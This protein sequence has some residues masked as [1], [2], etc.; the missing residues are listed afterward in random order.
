M[1][2]IL[3]AYFLMA[4]TFTLAKV[5]VSYM[6]PVYF[7]AFRMIL[8]GIMI[9][10]FL[11]AF[12]REKWRFQATDRWLL[13]QIVIFHI[14]C[15]YIFEFWAM[16][17][18]TSAKACLLYNLSPFITA[19]LCYLLYKQKLSLQKWSALILGFLGMFPIL[20]AHSSSEGGLL[21]IGFLSMAEIA[22]L[23]AVAAS[24]Y[25]WIVMKEL[26]VI[27]GY[28]PVMVNGIGML[29]GG[30]AALSTA[31]AFEGFSPFIWVQEPGDMVG[32]M[33]LP[34]L[35]VFPNTVVMALGSMICLIIIANI[36]GYNLYGYLLKRYS[37]TFLSFCGFITP[38][39]ASIFGWFFLS[40]CVTMP[41]FISLGIT[42]ISLYLFYK[43]EI[44]SV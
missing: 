25:G 3:L 10:G 36:I 23:A 34:H 7:I 37:P 17:Y 33:L 11:Y 15:A 1:W 40:E 16:Q 32:R 13:A 44:I 8:A 41:F 2:L 20:A 38:F 43:D 21:S 4:S 22:L 24:A 35:G 26:I 28:S 12:K 31:V 6:L 9:L 27:K 14:Y 39:F 5:A 19:L 30:L 29:G 42:I 18:V